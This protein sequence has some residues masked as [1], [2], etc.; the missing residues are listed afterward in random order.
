V[1]LK[2]IKAHVLT[3]ASRVAK[4]VEIVVLEIND[5]LLIRT[6]EPCPADGPLIGNSPVEDL[7]AGGDLVDDETRQELTEDRQGLADSVAGDASMDW[8]EPTSEI[9]HPR[10]IELGEVVARTHE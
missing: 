10:A 4:Y 7:R 1:L 2:L 8:P 5:D 9:M 3:D 6:S